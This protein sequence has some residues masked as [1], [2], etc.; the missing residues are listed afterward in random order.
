MTDGVRTQLQRLVEGSDEY[1]SSAR[2]EMLNL[3]DVIDLMLLE[4]AQKRFL[5]TRYLKP[6]Q[7][8]L[9]MGRWLLFYYR[10]IGLLKTL[11]GVLVRPCSL[12]CGS[13]PCL[14]TCA[15]CVL[16]AARWC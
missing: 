2:V 4:P 6:R 8:N 15:F 16:C 3:G 10:I 7:N 14:G 9:R 11:T 1:T 5:R 13:G 12:C